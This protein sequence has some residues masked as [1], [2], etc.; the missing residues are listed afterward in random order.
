MIRSAS[1]CFSS[2][3]YS[4][5]TAMFKYS[6]YGTPMPPVEYASMPKIGLFT[7]GYEMFHDFIIVRKT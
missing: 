1:R 6:A 3:F 7:G 2:D 4:T 5:A